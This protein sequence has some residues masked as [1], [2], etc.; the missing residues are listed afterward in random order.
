MT[1]D[2]HRNSSISTLTAIHIGVEVVA[3]AGLAYWQKKQVSALEERIVVLEKRCREYEDHL[4]SQGAAIEHLMSLSGYH[5][6]PRPPPPQSN[7]VH[8]RPAQSSPQQAPGQQSTSTKP[9][10]LPPQS[11]PQPPQSSTQLPPQ[12]Q[13]PSVPPPQPPPV[14]TEEELDEELKDELAK[15]SAPDTQ[16]IEVECSDECDGEVCPIDTEV[17]KKKSS[18]KSRKTGKPKKK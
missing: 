15:L 10:P 2:G 14:V 6:E 4:R 13:P 18:S 3:I 8:R 11:S 1:D 5:A 7:L 9:N 16:E 12:P 17:L